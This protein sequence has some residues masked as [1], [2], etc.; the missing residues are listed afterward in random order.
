MANKVTR[1]INCAGRQIP[2]HWEPI[3]VSYM[4]FYWMD[5]DDQHVLDGVNEVA[6]QTFDFI[7]QALDRT[8]SV[9]VNSVRGQSRASVVIAAYMMRRY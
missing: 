3:G 4:T 9:L 5:Q 6:N 8:E 7:E 2:N 1:V